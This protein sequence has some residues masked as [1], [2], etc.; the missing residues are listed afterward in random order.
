MKARFRSN[1]FL[2]EHSGN[3][4][5]LPADRYQI[6]EQKPLPDNLYETL[7]RAAG[8]V[9]GNELIRELVEQTEVH[10]FE[11]KLPTMADIFISLVKGEGDEALKKH[12]KEV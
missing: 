3:S 2:V 12:L 9:K 6:V 5:Q 1:T 7:I 4:L 11:E 10:R 8:D